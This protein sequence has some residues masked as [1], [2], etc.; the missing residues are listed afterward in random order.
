VIANSQVTAKTTAELFPNALVEV[1]YCPVELQPQEAIP[2][3]SRSEIR[4]ELQ[5]PDEAVVI[6]MCC[7]LEAYKGH[8]LLLSSLARLQDDRRW[9]A[10]I[11]G[12]VQRPSDQSYLDSLIES[13]KSAGIADRVRFLGQRSDVPKLLAASDIHCQPNIDAEPFGIA[14][15]EAM[16]ASLPVVTTRLGGAIEVVGDECGVLVPPGDPQALAETLTRLIDDP[17]W[18]RSLGSA[19]PARAHQLCDPERILGRLETVLNTMKS[20]S[21]SP[22]P[23]PSPV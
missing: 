8:S 20:G 12:G 21:R 11:A 14:F 3:S 9:V 2:A 18:R 17:S 23:E 4:R 5:T 10:W 7:R 6:L 16:N 1:I 19:G 13:A 15:V 22:S